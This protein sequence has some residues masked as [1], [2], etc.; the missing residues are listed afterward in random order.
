VSEMLS[1][2]E[3]ADHCGI[4]VR[5]WQAKYLIWGVPHF[6]IGRAVKFKKSEL[7]TW[8]ESRRAA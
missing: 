4:P 8:I 1:N 3:A 7:D 6:R 2:R 5:T